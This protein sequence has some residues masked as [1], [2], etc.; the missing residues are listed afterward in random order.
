MYD[1]NGNEK[2]TRSDVHPCALVE[3]DDPI[4][5]CATCG[6]PVPMESDRGIYC[7]P[8]CENMALDNALW[9]NAIEEA[10]NRE[11]NVIVA[12]DEAGYYCSC[13]VHHGRLS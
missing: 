5:E 13:E 11:A 9:E 7:D 3:T 4:Q 2:P 12:I 10:K 6:L 8:A 1:A